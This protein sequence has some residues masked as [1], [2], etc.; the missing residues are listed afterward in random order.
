[1]ADIAEAFIAQSRSLLTSAYLPRIERC[2]EKLSDEEVWWRPHEEANSIGN[3]LLHLSG[4]VRQWIVSGVGARPDTRVRQQEFD[5]RRVLPRTEL[6]RR[7]R[8]TLS[9]A[10]AVLAETVPSR[11]LETRQIQGKDVTVLDAVY[12]VV[13]HFSMH[14]GQIILL[15]KLLKA[16]D[17]RFYDFSGGAPL[18]TWHTPAG[19]SST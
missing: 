4:N 11:L 8:E 18:E 6:L 19:E 9:E 10:D 12:H 7:L 1:M 17:L 15:T 13:E 14:T 16:E 5:E 2:L 3:L